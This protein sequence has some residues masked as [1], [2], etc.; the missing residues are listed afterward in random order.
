M[1][2]LIVPVDLL[3]VQVTGFVNRIRNVR[4][5]QNHNGSGNR[6]DAAN[7]AFRL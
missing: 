3:A 6:E 4:T 5:G 1:K 2:L 7:D